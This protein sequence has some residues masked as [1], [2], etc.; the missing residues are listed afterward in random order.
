MSKF[1]SMDKIDAN[2]VLPPEKSGGIDGICRC[3]KE[4][5]LHGHHGGILQ[6]FAHLNG[7]P[8]Y[9]ESEEAA[10]NRLQKKARLMA[11]D[12]VLHAEDCG[13]DED[14]GEDLF[15]DCKTYKNSFS[16]GPDPDLAH[17]ASRER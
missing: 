10:R 9:G 6:A 14:C 7:R 1:I 16:E 11:V 17:D 12:V 2:N 15:G 4:D 13:L 3:G 8:A 5:K